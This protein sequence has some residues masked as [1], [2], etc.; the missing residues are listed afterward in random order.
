MAGYCSCGLLL[1]SYMMRYVNASDMEIGYIFMIQPLTIF[2]RP[3]ICARAD[4]YQSHKSLLTGFLFGTS[5]SYIPFIVIPFLDKN[6]LFVNILTE[7]T[8]FWILAASHLVGSFCFCGIRSLGDA[9]AVNYAKRIGS[10]FTCYRKFGAL[11]FGICG[12]FLGLINQGWILPDYVASMIMYVFSMFLLA[13]LVYLW[14]MEFFVMV[15]ESTKEESNQLAQLPSGN[16]IRAHMRRK[17]KSFLSICNTNTAI[18]TQTNGQIMTSKPEQ[19]RKYL[20]TKQQVAIFMLLF[21]RDFRV[22][23]FLLFVFYG[24]LVGYAPQ[25]FVFT[26]MDQVCREHNICE[27]ASL[28]G[29]MMICYCLAETTCYL[30]INALRSRLNHVVVLEI[31]M[32]SLAI[33]YY[34]YAYILRNVSP[35]FFL[36]ESLHGLEYSA[37]LSTSMEL[38]YRF[39]N[40]VELLLPELIQRGIIGKHDDHHLVKVSLM[41]TINGC[42][43]LVYDGVGTVIGAFMYGM[44][45]DKFSF[46]TTWRVVGSLATSGFF[47]VLVIVLIGKCFNI[48]PQIHKMAAQR[49]SRSTDVPQLNA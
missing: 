33:H 41:A 40:E 30:I 26:Y 20:T 25:N 13:V 44:I 45:T 46:T 18:E 24:G 15:D 36:V 14:P 11:S 38:G 16:E 43:T 7:R 8:C 39:A 10:D 37:S 49:M 27:P 29:L 1:G 31:T 2:A 21:K 9:L 22:P 6:H 19:P 47:V 48:R 3:L 4:R 17:L 42:F 23:L 34:F 12:Y 28:A 5:I 32:V 35:Y